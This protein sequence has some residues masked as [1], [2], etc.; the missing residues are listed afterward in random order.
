M[1]GFSDTYDSYEAGKLTCEEAGALLGMGE[2]SF[3]RWKAR[4][5]AEGEAGLADKRVGKPSNRKAQDSETKLVNQL[6][7]EKY[8]GFNVK[9]YHQFLVEHHG[10]NRGYSFVKRTLEEAKLITKS[11]RGGDHRLRRPRK[12]MIGLM[13]HQD[14]STHRWFGEEN[15]DLVVTMDDATSEIYSAFFCK[16]EGTDSSLRGVKEVIEKQGLFCSFYSDRGSH[17][18]NTPE[19]GGKV[20]KSNLTQFG[21]AL[22]MLGIQQVAAYSPQAR[23]RS[24][25]MFSTLQGRLPNELKLN[26]INDID[27]ANEY[28]QKIYLPAHNKQFMVEAIDKTSAFLPFVGKNLDEIL[29][30]Q[31]TRVVSNDNT[32]RFDGK[33]LQIQKDVHRHHYVKCEVQ[34]HKKLDETLAVFYGN[35]C[36]GEFCHNGKPIIKQELNQMLKQRS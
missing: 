24:E 19:S 17:Y 4:F 20:D 6:Y 16:Q 34:V 22:K 5:E 3:R 13:I 9:H 32:V 14:A 23:G 33:I 28:L 25:R 21:R 18:W 11:K 15:S 31:E 12:P 35:R 29:C 26:N 10:L 8:H 7:A 30:V 27:A 36:L 2:R 1:L